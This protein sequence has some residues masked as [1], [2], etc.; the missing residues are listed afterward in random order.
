MY[1]DCVINYIQG[2]AQE[3]VLEDAFEEW[4]ADQAKRQ[5]DL[6][7]FIDDFIESDEYKDYLAFKSRTVKTDAATQ[8]SKT[9]A[10]ERAKKRKQPEKLYPLTLHSKKMFAFIRK[11]NKYL[12]N[13]KNKEALQKQLRGI[14]I[15]KD[16]IEDLKRYTVLY[17]EDIRERKERE[18]CE[19]LDEF[20]E[21]FQIDWSKL[22]SKDRRTKERMVSL[23]VALRSRCLDRKRAYAKIAKKIAEELRKEKLQ[24]RAFV[25]KVEKDEWIVDDLEIVGVGI[26]PAETKVSSTKTAVPVKITQSDVDKNDWS[27]LSSTMLFPEDVRNTS[28]ISTSSAAQKLKKTASKKI[29]ELVTP[30]PQVTNTRKKLTENFSQITDLIQQFKDFDEMLENKYLSSQSN[31]VQPY[32]TDECFLCKPAAI[33]FSNYDEGKECRKT[34]RI[35]NVSFE[36]RK[37]RLSKITSDN[38]YVLPLFNVEPVLQIQKVAPGRTVIAFVRFLPKVETCFYEAKIEFVSFDRPTQTHQ[39][40]SVEIKCVPKMIEF[41]ISTNDLYF[42]R[43]PL[44]QKKSGFRTITLAN[45]GH[46]PCR[47]IIKKIADPL[48][49]EEQEEAS[50]NE[51]EPSYT[52]IVI[53]EI[54]EELLDHMS[55]SFAFEST[56]VHLPKETSRTVK[57]QM[58]NFSHVGHYFEKHVVEV[59]N[60]DHN[61]IGTRDILLHGEVV[62]HFI[63]TKQDEVDFGFCIIN[64]AYQT[65]LDIENKSSSTQTVVIKYPSALADYVKTSVSNVFLPAKSTRSVW[66]KLFPKKKITSCPYFKPEYSILEF[67]LQLC[68]PSNQFSNVAPV[69]VMTYAIVTNCTDV[70]VTPA[71]SEM[72]KMDPDGV[73]LDLGECT[74]YETVTA[75]LVVENKTL[76]PQIYGFLDLP[77]CLT[78]TPNYGFGL[79]MS[80]AKK[81]LKLHFHPDYQD[82]LK[83]FNEDKSDDF[84]LKFKIN[85]VTLFNV[86]LVTKP[87]DPKVLRRLIM[88]MLNEI[89]HCENQQLIEDI[90]YCRQTIKIELYPDSEYTPY[91]NSLSMTSQNLTMLQFEQEHGE[92]FEEYHYPS[93]VN[94]SEFINSSIT[95]QS[96]VVQPWLRT[97]VQY[98]EFPD[99]PYSSYSMADFELRAF[100]RKF[101]E[102]TCVVRKRDNRLPAFEAW[103][104][105]TSD[106]DDI[107]VEPSCGIL[108]NGE[109]RRIFIIVQPTVSEDVVA[110]FAK[111]IK[112]AEIYAMKM[113]QFETSRRS[114]KFKK[115]KTLTKKFK[116]GSLLSTDRE[117]SISE[118][119][120]HISDSQL[121]LSPEEYF[122]AEMCYWRSLQ[123]F[124]VNSKLTCH[125]SYE[126]KN[127]CR[128]NDRLHVD[129]VYKVVRPD[130]I[131]NNVTSQRIDF[132]NVI[133]GTKGVQHVMVQNIKYDPIT[134]K[135]SQLDPTGPFRVAYIKNFKIPPECHLKIPIYFEPTQ[136]DKQIEEY[137][138]ISSGKT[139]IPLVINGTG[140]AYDLEFVPQFTVC[141]MT[142]ATPKACDECSIKVNNNSEGPVTLKFDKILEIEEKLPPND[143]SEKISGDDIVANNSAV[144]RDKYFKRF[145]SELTE[146]EYT[147]FVDFNKSTEKFFDVL[148]ESST[149]TIPANSCVTVNIGFGNEATLLEKKDIKKKTKP[150][151]EGK[152]PADRTQYHVA[153]Y[154]VYMDKTFIKDFIFIGILKLNE[155]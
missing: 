83:K 36:T 146:F 105:I 52:N 12:E 3:E 67:P 141:R 89:R 31:R 111:S 108:R 117:T 142:E 30:I 10:H 42:G 151:M 70:S 46:L 122:P 61:I 29:I 73:L 34:L 26:K 123:P 98:V 135:L 80:G 6:I 152:L 91:V 47:A 139:V 71:A 104:K 96:K 100:N 28:V 68:V 115:S 136:Q 97:S 24:R 74:V 109:T 116:G 131:L 35:Q 138:E 16:K 133:L 78:I 72:A 132:G 56:C 84:T 44:W 60:G 154:N 54:I 124:V 41:T 64:S 63:C 17:A 114:D 95:V 118:A 153:K 13:S 140:V 9:D 2:K 121:Q 143:S 147:S 110:D 134:I 102:E 99:V 49:D 5:E 69:K 43:I 53:R 27:V 15:I 4:K 40:F 75:D 148:A 59:Y 18:F 48:D 32:K 120:I 129:V 144:K 145:S 33:I 57:V 150:K 55:D 62:G 113:E 126:C 1:T 77:K 82:L 90:L 50:Y 87:I 92:D 65:Q 76:T 119:K 22:V 155:V 8:Y 107:R 79:I 85:L 103:F 130:F 112:Y 86:R 7:E 45:R 88:I 128:A 106:N 81:I 66:I 94:L 58:K 37:F 25:Y 23:S 127:A 20:G 93:E 39:Q 137:L 14:Q 51:L 38:P 125:V 149:I 19:L 11:F 21:T 101:P